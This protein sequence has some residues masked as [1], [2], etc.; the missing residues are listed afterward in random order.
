MHMVPYMHSLGGESNTNSSQQAFSTTW[1][2]THDG[3]DGWF[4]SQRQYWLSWR[5]CGNAGW[6][7]VFTPRVSHSTVLWGET[8]SII[9]K[10]FPEG[11]NTAA[12]GIK[13]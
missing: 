7:G 4:P 6:R 1:R 12:L 2:N 13:Q 3:A 8:G 5:A 9:S 10:A 11:A